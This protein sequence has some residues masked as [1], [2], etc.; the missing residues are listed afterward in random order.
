MVWPRKHFLF[1]RF[2]FLKTFIFIF[3]AAAL[4]MAPFQMWE[5]L[6]PNYAASLKVNSKGQR[7]G[8]GVRL[9]RSPITVEIP[10]ENLSVGGI[11]LTSKSCKRN[12]WL[13]A[14]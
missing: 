13:T 12:Y 3:F 1:Y 11:V 7:P 5:L 2:R 14:T 10:A 9:H 8:S 6:Q 4:L